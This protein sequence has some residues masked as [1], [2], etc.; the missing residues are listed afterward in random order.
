MIYLATRIEKDYI[1]HNFYNNGYLY[2]HEVLINK[3]I[4]Y[5]QYGKT[6]LTNDTDSYKDCDVFEYELPSVLNSVGYIGFV[7]RI[8]CL[9]N[10]IEQKIFENI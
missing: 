1:T 2:S 7:E 8:E 3:S 5:N 10:I 6:K 9:N 4:T